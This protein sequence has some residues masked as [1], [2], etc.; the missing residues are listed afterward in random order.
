MYAAWAE[1]PGELLPKLAKHVTVQ[2]AM[3]RP[4]E[5]RETWGLLPEHRALGGNLVREPGLEAG[6]GRAP[7]MERKADVIDR[8]SKARGVKPPRRTP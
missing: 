5:A 7:A 1:A 6:R 3:L 8:W 2:A 4:E